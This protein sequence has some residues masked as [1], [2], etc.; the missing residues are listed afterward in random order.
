MAPGGLLIVGESESLSR[1]DLGFVFEQPL[2]YRN[3]PGRQP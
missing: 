1:F 3:P 2:I